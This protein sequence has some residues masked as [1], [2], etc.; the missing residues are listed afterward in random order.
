MANNL[1]ERT[2]EYLKAKLMYS[3]IL[4]FHQSSIMSMLLFSLV[5][6]TNY[7]ESVQT[8]V[9]QYISAMFALFCVIYL[10]NYIRFL[11][12][13]IYQRDEDIKQFEKEF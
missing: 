7:T 13:K 10:L 11:T 4:A 3:A 6:L 8:T 2:I 9:L 1:G 5:N 12:I